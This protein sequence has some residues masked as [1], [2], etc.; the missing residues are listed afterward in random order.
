MITMATGE[1]MS[2]PDVEVGIIFFQGVDNDVDNTRH[3]L[4]SLYIYLFFL[5]NCSAGFK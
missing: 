2:S 4:M 3:V 1:V 5:H